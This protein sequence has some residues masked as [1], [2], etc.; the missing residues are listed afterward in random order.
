MVVVLLLM[1]IWCCWKGYVFIWFDLM[2]I[3]IRSDS[4]VEVCYT[5][6]FHVVVVE[7]IYLQFSL[8]DV[9]LIVVDGLLT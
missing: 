6:V 3:F 1:L 4:L 8:Y 2:P 9:L 5:F 7:G